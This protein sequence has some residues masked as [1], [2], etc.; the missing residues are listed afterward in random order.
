M[1]TDNY[2]N[3]WMGEGI[4]TDPLYPADGPAPD[5][6]LGHPY[7][8]GAPSVADAKRALS[9]VVAD[10]A[11]PDVNVVDPEHHLL[12]TRT[13]EGCDNDLTGRCLSGV[14]RRSAYTK[15][16]VM[17]GSTPNPYIPVSTRTVFND[18]TGCT[19]GTCWTQ[20]TQSDW[21][22]AGRF[23]TMKH[24]SNFPDGVNFETY[25]G[26]AQWSAAQTLDA[27]K[28]WLLDLVSEQR[29]T[30]NGVTSKTLLCSDPATGFLNRSR[31]LAGS[32]PG[33]TDVVTD[34]VRTVTPESDGSKTLRRTTMTYGGDLPSQNVGQPA[35]VCAQTDLPTPRYVLRDTFRYGALAT[36]A[37]LDPQSFLSNP[38]EILRVGDYDINRNTALVTASRDSAGVATAYAYKT[39]GS[40]RLE[41]ITPTGAAPTT[42]SYTNASTTS[43][44]RVAVT[45]TPSD[46]LV[47]ST[48]QQIEFD[49]FGRILRTSTLMPNDRWA[50]T[51]NR[52]DGLGRKKEAVVPVES[53]TPP[54]SA[55][56]GNVTAFQYDAFDRPTRVTTPDNAQVTTAYTGSRITSRTS[57][58]AT[59]EAGTESLVT[60]AEEYDS[61]G[62]LRRVREASGADGA[63]TRTD[64]GYEVGGKLASVKMYLCETCQP[65]Q[66]RTFNYDLRGFLTKETHPESGSTSYELYDAAGHATRKKQ[67]NGGTP[68]DLEFVYDSAER[69]VFLN[70]ANPAS[71]GTFRPLK[72]FTFA[73]ANGT[74]DFVSG[75]LQKAVRHNYQPALGD[76]VVTES[77]KYGGRGGRASEKRTTVDVGGIRMQEFFQKFDYNELGLR[78]RTD[79]PTCLTTACGAA[80]SD[81]V[82]YSYSRGLLSAVTAK[83]GSASK[84]FAN[85]FT[86]AP[87]GLQ[88]QMRHG[89]SVI[90]RQFG[91][92]SGMA[93]PLRFEVS[94]FSTTPGCT[95]PS[96]DDHPDSQAVA[97]NT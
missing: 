49:G 42:I 89:N 92:A 25:S 16:A 45:T 62:R 18:D 80:N 44:A 37:Y 82:E 59:S 78:S 96:V 27:N 93:R 34:Y 52:Y 28:P 76:V 33:G 41:T 69:L 53:D 6:P 58:I 10:V 95:A 11:M 71:P 26:F 21:N 3:V 56:A 84:V 63:E 30:E 5:E 54:T 20:S 91:D 4:F 22:G 67:G 90:D 61:Q 7:T 23:R 1:R 38:V 88:S 72:G 46:P 8:K 13:F 83:N 48:S 57:K 2:F 17:F 81:A 29:R 31:V 68:F 79:Y 35:D 39:D 87:N 32:T 43:N 19:G 15:Y 77:Y 50:V 66:E 65:S 73:P 94:G 9:D 60:V 85:S 14:L 51:E 74:N 47:S 24:S 70:A 12:S 40:G 55:V 97:P 86:Y 75:K 64:Y 36:S